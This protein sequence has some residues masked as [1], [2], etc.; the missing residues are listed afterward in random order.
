MNKKP[1]KPTRAPARR[2]IVQAPLAQLPKG[3]CDRRA[4]GRPRS[5]ET[6][7]PS[8]PPAVELPLGY[9]KVLGELKRRIEQTRGARA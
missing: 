5:E 1:S 6:L 2:P 4:I 9:A 8:H 7:F 3:A